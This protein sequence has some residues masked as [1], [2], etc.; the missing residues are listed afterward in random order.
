MAT[1][2]F[3]SLALVVAAAESNLEALQMDD[4]CAVGEDCS[5]E[6]NQLRAMKAGSFD[7]FRS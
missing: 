5:L 1:K 3:W 7:G 4:A 2:L 6:L